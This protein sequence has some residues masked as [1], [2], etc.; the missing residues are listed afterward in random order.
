MCPY[1]APG[2]FRVIPTGS[3]PRPVRIFY[4]GRREVIR[5]AKSSLVFCWATRSC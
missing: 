2:V 5:S 4:A 1:G 3:L